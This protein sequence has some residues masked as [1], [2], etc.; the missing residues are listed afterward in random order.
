MATA[1]K[2]NS[3][4]SEKFWFRKSL[5]PPRPSSLRN[6]NGSSSSASSSATTS[7]LATPP[8][9]GTPAL[10]GPVEDEYCLMT[11]NE[12]MNG[13]SGGEEFVGLIP[14]IESYLDTVN[15]DVETRC[16]LAR[17]LSLVGKRASGEFQTGATWIREFVRNHPDYKKDSVI[18]EKINYDLMKVVER[19]GREGRVE[20]I[21]EKLLGKS[22]F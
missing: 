9:P 8:R 3:V 16:A 10:L 5:F 13:K 4:L 18:S 20:G 15:V 6:L 11:I 12:I 19:L 7:P 2:R 14:L 1:H 21:S 17:Y 22:Y